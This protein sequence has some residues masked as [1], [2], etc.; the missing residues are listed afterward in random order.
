[1]DI[2]LKQFFLVIFGFPLLLFLIQWLLI[3]CRLPWVGML[4][5]LVLLLISMLVVFGISKFDSNSFPLEDW[6]GNVL[7]LLVL[8]SYTIVVTIITTG[9]GLV[10][11]FAY[12]KLVWKP[13][14]IIQQTG[15]IPSFLLLGAIFI[16][17]VYFVLTINRVM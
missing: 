5:N 11:M 15:K 17:M 16:C 4:V 6:E 1:M 9:A 12:R 14:E 8:G 10:L 2:L 13:G 7:D 3:K